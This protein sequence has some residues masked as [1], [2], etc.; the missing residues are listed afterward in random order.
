MKNIYDMEFYKRDR[1]KYT[2]AIINSTSKKKLVIGGPG[3]GKTYLFKSLLSKVRSDSGKPG[4]VLTFIK[5]LVA[6]LETDLKGLA[7]VSTF[8][9]Y[10]KSILDTFKNRSF[11]YYPHILEVIAKDFDIL[12]Q[13]KCKKEDIEKAFF[14]LKD[15][16]LIKLT[17]K[18][19]DYYNAGGHTDSV[20]RVTRYFESDHERIPVYPLVIFD[21]YQ[22]FNF[23][24]TKL[25][26]LLYSK[27]PVLIVGDDDQA[28]YG[29][30]QASPKYIRQLAQNT[31]FK[32]FELPYCSRCTK[33]IV[34]ATMKVISKAKENGLLKDR[35]DKPFK[36]F[37]PDKHADSQANPSIIN[38]NCSVERNNCH[39]IGKYIA[40]EISNIPILCIQ[41]SEK[42]PEPTVLV[43]GPKQ[44]LNGVKNEI[45]KKFNVDLEEK[46]EDKIDILDGYK[47]I[48]KNPKSR[49]GWRILLHFD[50]CGNAE[51]IISDSISTNKDIIDS[52]VS[53]KYISQHCELS[54]IVKKIS[55]GLDLIPEERQKIEA[56]VSLS[57]EEI[58]TK[59][60]DTNREDSTTSGQAPNNKALLPRILCT[61]FEGSKGLAAQYVFIV[62]VN[63]GH[64]PRKNP[65]QDIDIFRLIVGLTRT[66]KRCYMISCNH[67]GSER[68]NP[69]I[70]KA[71]L[72]KELSK[73]I[74]VDK[75]YV[76]K[77]C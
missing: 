38:V 3:T 41:D 1:Q 18:I 63:E 2:D 27:S 42:H 19:G 48:A 56:G 33:V 47:M 11:E 67:F 72:G 43:I 46:Q 10:C 45:S 54:K 6:D 55:L 30:K 14:S 71:W 22:D 8:H 15:K 75:D 35:I 36:Y 73:E 37:P 61:S 16:D 74:Y 58:K 12:G 31:E 21:E 24:E 32:K 51:K 5:N 25:A 34:R 66:R 52:I 59:L 13:R 70:Y 40:K 50:P 77:F 64:F 28:L 65:P 26:E 69:S 4:L 68:L 39:Y 44:F 76:N 49:L 57:F 29:F 60:S 9:A 23:I 53:N 20:Y 17:I 7:K 62:G